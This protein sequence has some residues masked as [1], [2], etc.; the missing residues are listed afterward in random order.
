MS[1]GQKLTFI[2]LIRWRRAAEFDVGYGAVN[3]LKY[4]IQ[5]AKKLIITLDATSTL[6]GNGCWVAMIEFISQADP[7]AL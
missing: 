2:G 7:Q 4:P 5:M 1:M 6:D 3:S